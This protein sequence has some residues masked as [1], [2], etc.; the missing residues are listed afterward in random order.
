[1]TARRVV[2]LNAGTATLKVAVFEIDFGEL[3]ETYRAEGAWSERADGFRLVRLPTAWSVTVSASSRRLSKSCSA[4]WAVR[5]MPIGPQPETDAPVDA[6]R[7]RRM[8][9]RES[10]ASP[11]VPERGERA[12]DLTQL[13]LNDDVSLTTPNAGE[14]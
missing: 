7:G 13:R 10:A 3:A 8:R 9:R 6:C 4:P 2:V 5:G 1:M 11:C 14:R 12:G